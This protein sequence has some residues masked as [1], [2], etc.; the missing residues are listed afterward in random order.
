MACGQNGVLCLPQQHAVHYTQRGSKVDCS[1]CK[2]KV[3]CPFVSVVRDTT[4]EQHLKVPVSANAVISQL[5][6]Q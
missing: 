4:P 5:G 1:V 2:L 3:D 6:K